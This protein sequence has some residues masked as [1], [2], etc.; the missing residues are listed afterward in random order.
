MSNADGNGWTAEVV[1]DGAQNG[2]SYDDIVLMPGCEIA[3]E[4]AEADLTTRLTRNISLQLPLI[5]SPSDAVTEADMAI[6]LA[7]AGGIGIVHCNQ[8]LPSQ[9]EMVKRVK[10]RDNGFI[11][12]PLTLSP[13]NTVEDVDQ[14]KESYGFSG[15]PITDNGELGGRI[16]GIVTARDVD[17]I[18][19]RTM[20][21]QDVMT[22]QLVLGRDGITLAGA[23]EMLEK[24][25]VGKLPI[26]NDEMCLISMV[27]RTDLKRARGDLKKATRDSKGRLMVGAAVSVDGQGDWERAMALI[28]A[29]ADFLFLDTLAATNGKEHEFIARLKA[30]VPQIDIAAGPVSACRE[31]KFMCD[32]GVDAVVV[33]SSASSLGAGGECNSVGRPEATAT[34]QVARYVSQNYGLPVIAQG[35]LRNPGQVLKAL[36]LGASAV[37]LDE[38]LTAAWQA[39]GRDTQRAGACA[40]LATQ[41]SENTVAVQGATGR[42]DSHRLSEVTCESANIAVV[43]KGTVRDLVPYIAS[44]LR[45]GFCDLNTR[46]VPDLH[47]ALMDGELRLEIRSFFGQKQAEL[48]AL[49]QQRSLPQYV[50]LSA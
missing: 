5:G 43:S 11:Y 29:G 13:E 34:F 24:K 41:G 38:L 16:L 39:P 28:E 40:R 3:W 20:R 44:G 49:S 25:K 1:F 15:I 32:A 9:V 6:G 26:V 23:Y 33:G 7:L 21:L 30:E 48:R 42:H 45:N 37:M 35:G 22:K 12:E 27:S 47:K 4:A 14:V 17:P 31:A 19:D 10:R 18:D 50:Q 8:S 46:S 36:G 2:Y